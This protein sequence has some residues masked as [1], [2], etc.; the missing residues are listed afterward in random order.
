[1][2]DVR[3]GSVSRVADIV[4]AK[5]VLKRSVNRET[6]EE[7][8]TQSPKSTVHRYLKQSLKLK[9]IKLRLQPK[10]TGSQRRWRLEFAVAR[11]NSSLRQGARRRS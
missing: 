2:G 1:M 8:V 9:P 3:R 5:S 11:R 7:V 10:Q 6:G 4:L